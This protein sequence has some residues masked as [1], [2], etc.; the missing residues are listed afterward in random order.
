MRRAFTLVEL[1]VVLAILGVL[2]SLVMPA[3]QQARE[4]ARRVECRNQLRQLGL[5][6]HSYHDAKLVLPT[7]AYLRGPSFPVQS[8]WGWGAMILPYVDQPALY[9]SLDFNL[10]TGIGGNLPQ[11]AR[12]VSVWRCPSDAAP[13]AA[14]VPTWDGV[15]IECATG[16]YCGSTGMLSGMSAVRFADVTD[17]LSNTFLLGERVT[18]PSTTGSDLVTSGWYGILAS[19]TSYVFNSMPFTTASAYYRINLIMGSATN[20]SSRHSGGAHFVLGDGSV[21][22]VSQDIDG[23]LFEAIGTINGQEVAE[24]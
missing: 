8:G 18:H 2:L 7:G 19:N 16:N 10:P 13:A 21:R 23:T 11:I 5:A 14:L 24:F 1:L 6:L 9:H 20:F 17:G 12:P 4:S 3:V 15:A 22:F